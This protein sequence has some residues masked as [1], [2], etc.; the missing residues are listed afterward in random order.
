MSWRIPGSAEH[1]Y[2]TRTIFLHWTAL[3][4]TLFGLLLSNACSGFSAPA[5][6]STA[7]LT[8]SSV[9]PSATL[10]SI[11]ST[12]LN[13]SG[14][15]PPYGFS[16][17]SGEFP[18]GLFLGSTTGTILGT[19]TATGSFSFAILVSDSKGISKQ[20]SLQNNG[21]QRSRGEPKQGVL[22][23]SAKR[24]MGNLWANAAKLCD[25]FAVALRWNHLFDV[26]GDWH[27]FDERR[28]DAI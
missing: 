13:V 21:S 15:T 19:P 9:L 5:T 22:K 6:N 18:T 16:L 17:T 24:R 14:G 11:Y 8:I 23:S 20:Q 2:P 26:S 3:T 1:K 10:G 27:P 25:L 28:L 7:S 12:T 4:T